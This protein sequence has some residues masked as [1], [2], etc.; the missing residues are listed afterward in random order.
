MVIH[1][2]CRRMLL[3]AFLALALPGCAGG[4]DERHGVEK[5]LDSFVQELAAT[6]IDAS[7]LPARLRAYL[8]RNPGFFGSTVT[9]LGADQKALVSPYVYKAGEGYAEKNLVEPGYDIDSQAWLAK[10]RDSKTATW[11]EPYFDAGGG[12]IWMIT[13]TVPLMKD[14]VVYAVVTTD[15]PTDK[16]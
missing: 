5:A 7:A 13:R 15:L 4:G 14:G 1:S 6:P 2:F 3:C 12:E 9:L 16:P 8:A 11:T 10:A